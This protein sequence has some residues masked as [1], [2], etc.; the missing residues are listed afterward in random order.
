MFR[1][2]R[3]LAHGVAATQTSTVDEPVLQ[4]FDWTAGPS[5]GGRQHT[6][7]LNNSHML[8][9]PVEKRSAYNLLD[10]GFVV[11]ERSGERSHLIDEFL[12]L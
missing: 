10:S 4:D 8:G 1:N 9:F 11:H 7:F 3:R 6:F 5:G 2:L 12:L